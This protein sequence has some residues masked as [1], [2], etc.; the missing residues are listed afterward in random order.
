[1]ARVFTVGA[2]VLRA[3]RRCDAENRTH[4]LD[5]EWKTYL[6]Q[7]FGELFAEVVATG[8]RYFE[9]T[10]DIVADG[11]DS[12]TE[13]TN[14]LS[15]V[16]IDRIIDTTTGRRRPLREL[17]A[18]ERDFY[19]GR[20]GEACAYMQVDDQVFLLP[21]PQSGTYQMV[22]VP[23]PADLS[24]AD[25]SDQI[26]LVV[27]AGE[28]FVVEHMAAQGLDKEEADSSRAVAEREAA[29]ARVIEWA[30]LRA[31]NNPRRRIVDR[32][33]SYDY[34]YGREGDWWFFY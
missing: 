12:Y 34:P 8:M 23:Q 13:P 10:F 11:S 27:P 24:A 6:S 7:A 32:F 29:R 17:M 18:Q 16:G 3:K 21:K 4:I 15:L 19:S 22:Y 20:N 25:D 28:Q 26:D 14:M 5:P 33:D 30:T 2:L 31:L 1:M 9:T